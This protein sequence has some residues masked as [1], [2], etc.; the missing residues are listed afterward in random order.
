[1]NAT[2]TALVRIACL[3]A[4]LG[5]AAA[6]QI[7][8]SLG[9]PPTTLGQDPPNMQP[10]LPPQP[11]VP[12]PIGLDKPSKDPFDPTWNR[13][14]QAQR[15][16]GF[17][18]FP[19]RLST[20][21]TYPPAAGT[22]AQI[23]FVPSLP[24]VDPD[25]ADWPSWTRL[26]ART[27]VP[28][29]FDRAMLVRHADRVWWRKNRDLA[30]IPLYFYDKI[31]SI[32]VGGEVQ[33]RHAGEFELLLFD[34]G[35]LVAQGPTDLRLAESTTTNVHVEV[36]EF[37]RLRLQGSKREHTFTLPDGSRLT[38]PVNPPDAEV[39][40]PTLV[41]LDRPAEPGWFEGRATVFNVGPRDVVFANSLGTT[42]IQ[43]GHRLV[44]FLTPPV[45][46]MSADV[47]A[48]TAIAV[49]EGDALRLEAPVAGS[50]SWCGARIA[51]P[52]NGVVRLLPLQ[53]TPFEPPAD[54]SGAAAPSKN[55]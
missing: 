49:H 39:G 18:V 7:P 53:G 26:R 10:Y 27:G 38:I 8:P 5:A 35:R 22:G 15:F 11:G 36:R 34:S 6:Q 46:P 42:T 17:P 14:D 20:Y 47:D 50:I 25:V 44:M 30:F 43:P 45:A 40:G 19:S 2:R 28:F 21:G 54:P 3:S 55:P 31:G 41:V 51:L 32:G 13:L 24:P 1:M 37:T 12:P 33:V 16:Q 48:G 23:P 29:T 4:L 9:T 52:A